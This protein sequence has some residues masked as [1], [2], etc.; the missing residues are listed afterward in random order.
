ARLGGT[1]MFAKSRRDFLRDA[2][3]LGAGLALTPRT[4]FGVE[5]KGAA[6]DS[7]RV[8][9]LGGNGRGLSHVG[10]F[11][12]KHNCIVSTICDHDCAVVDR[13]LKS[14]SE[15]QGVIPR[16]EPDLRRVFDDK[17]IDL[18][19]IATPNHWHAL[20]AIW[21]MQAGK[22]VYVEK[23]VSHNVLEGQRIVEA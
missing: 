12:G 18:I 3:M 19:T 11:A 1:I 20:A 7:L 8:A 16:Y 23:P 5:P 10:S 13:A 4:T 21:A 9:V 22:H 14:A 17:S 6:A 2:A 15:A